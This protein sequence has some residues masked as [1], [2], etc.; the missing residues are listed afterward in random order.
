M[1]NTFDSKHE[2]EFLIPIIFHTIWFIL[3]NLIIFS[4]QQ[5]LFSTDCVISVPFQQELFSTDCVISAQFQVSLINTG[6]FLIIM[7]SLMKRNI[8]R[9]HLSLSY[10]I[11]LNIYILFIMTSCII[12]WG[13]GEMEMTSLFYVKLIIFIILILGELAM[14]SYFMKYLMNTQG[15]ENLNRIQER[16][17]IV[18]DGWIIEQ[19][20]TLLNST[21]FTI[22][23]A[24]CSKIFLL[25]IFYNN[26]ILVTT[27]NFLLGKYQK[28]FL[29]EVIIS[30]L[31]FIIR[32]VGMVLHKEYLIQRVILLCLNMGGLFLLTHWYYGVIGGREENYE[33]RIKIIFYVIFHSLSTFYISVDIKYMGVGLNG[34]K[35]ELGMSKIILE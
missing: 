6:I 25:L 22:I 20:L 3:K 10:T 21:H 17:C 24:E 26:N 13:G 11:S 30:L 8:I 5:E 28:L 34:G 4:F 32:S 27:N 18:D 31:S 2:K 19:K 29:G 33:E 7:T 35:K 15:N 1:K 9:Y 16:E 23:L 12:I 14:T